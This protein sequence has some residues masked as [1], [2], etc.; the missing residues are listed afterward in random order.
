MAKRIALVFGTVAVLLSLAGFAVALMSSV[1]DE[2]S[3]VGPPSDRAVQNPLP[4]SLEFS[5]A[6]AWIEGDKATVFFSIT[7]IGGDDT[8]TDAE[9]DFGQESQFFGRSVCDNDRGS[10]ERRDSID[11]AAM[12]WTI[13]KPAG[14]RLELTDLTRELR[15]GESFELRLTFER[16]G[17]KAL[18]IRTAASPVKGP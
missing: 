14:C 2:P 7:N 10:V 11:V 1:D 15:P 4:P 8:L 12:D 9:S 13:L 5:G 6:F 3:T 18:T 16:A 17:V